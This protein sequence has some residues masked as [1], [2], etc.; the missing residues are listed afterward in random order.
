MTQLTLCL[1]RETEEKMKVAAKA[2]GMS[3]SQWVA[4]LIR[5]RVAS[6][7]PSSIASLAGAWKDDFPTL[8]EIRQGTG[9]E[10]QAAARSDVM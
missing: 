7:W 5:E 9:D 1:D 10:R 8:E 6:G 3:Q 2:A 4:S